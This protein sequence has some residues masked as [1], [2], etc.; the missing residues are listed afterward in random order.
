M[1]IERLFQVLAVILIGVAAFFLW[2]G[3]KDRTFVTAVFGAVSYFISLRFQVR[4]RLRLR[5]EQEEAE[6]RRRQ[7][8]EIESEE[9][10][11]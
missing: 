11:E 2:Q 9:E 10:Q 8:L 6:E 5:K 4:E 3:D 7:E 1:K